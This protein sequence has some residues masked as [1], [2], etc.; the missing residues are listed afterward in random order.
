M[1]FQ[2]YLDNIKYG[3]EISLRLS[4]INNIPLGACLQDM[5]DITSYLFET[6]VNI[7]KFMKIAWQ[8][9]WFLISAGFYNLI[10]RK[11]TLQKLLSYKN[12]TFITIVN[13]EYKMNLKIN[14]KRVYALNPSNAIDNTIKKYQ[15][16]E[17]NNQ[18]MFYARLIYQK[19]LFDVIYIH[20]TIVECLNIKLIISGKFQRKFEKKEFFKLVKKLGM[21]T[22]IEYTGVLSD[23]ELYMKLSKSKLLI[24]PSHSDSFS[25]SVLQALFLHVPV[26]AYDIPGLSLYK[27][28]KCVSLVKEFDTVSMAEEAVNFLNTKEKLFDQSELLTFIENHSSWEFVAKSHIYAI[29]NNLNLNSSLFT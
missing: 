6:L 8:I 21:E 16:N 26:V 19:G 1:N 25:I 12:L 14:F 22:F 4:R 9:S 28:F 15:T 17:K 10:N 3:G 5:G 20:K 13:N 27:N 18:I 7:R 2:Y 24:Y 29:N 23:E 11:V